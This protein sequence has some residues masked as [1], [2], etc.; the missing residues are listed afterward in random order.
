MIRDDDHERAC[1]ICDEKCWI[2][3]TTIIDVGYE[4]SHYYK[5][6]ELFVCDGDDIPCFIYVNMCKKTKRLG[7]EFFL[8]C[9]H[10]FLLVGT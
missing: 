2:F 7:C 4:M 6:I 9:A 10:I 5:E 3:A 8:E 1:L